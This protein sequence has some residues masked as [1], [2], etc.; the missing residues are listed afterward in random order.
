VTLSGE[1][2]DQGQ[3]KRLLDPLGTGGEK[4]P[5]MGKPPKLGCP[6]VRD[7]RIDGQLGGKG[8]LNG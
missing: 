5:H 3:G 2:Y 4:A 1:L 8:V 6:R 7:I